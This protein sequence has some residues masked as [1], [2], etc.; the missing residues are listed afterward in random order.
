MTF[1]TWVGFK[2]IQTVAGGVQRK[3]YRSTVVKRLANRDRNILGWAII[4]PTSRW[5]CGSRNLNTLFT[6]EICPAKISTWKKLKVPRQKWKK[7]SKTTFWAL[8]LWCLAADV[9]VMF[10][11]LW[12]L[13]CL[14]CSHMDQ[15]CLT[16]R[17]K[18][19]AK[20]LYLSTPGVF[21]GVETL[22]FL[23]IP[24]I[25]KRHKHRAQ[26][27]NRKASPNSLLI[28]EHLHLNPVGDIKV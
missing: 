16:R 18:R 4:H 17:K 13:S 9:S 7:K 1:V 25:I 22:N 20:H 19:N 27:E 14:T 24:N 26:S 3:H 21:F 2:A 10:R 11:A 28:W 6:A 8:K 5:Q 15:K 23:R 12:R